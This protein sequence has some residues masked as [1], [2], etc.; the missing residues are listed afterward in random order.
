M[1]VMQLLEIGS[2]PDCTTNGENCGMCV[3]GAKES[4]SFLSDNE[5]LTLQIIY[6]L[7]LQFA[8]RGVN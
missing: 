3:W 8:R 7:C 4:V 5:R 6:L 1:N 2:L